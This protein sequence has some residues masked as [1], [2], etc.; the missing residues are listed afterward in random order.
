MRVWTLYPERA[1]RR[2]SLA[3]IPYS[4]WTSKASF[5]IPAAAAWTAICSMS[6]T[7]CVPR[8]TRIPVRAR[9]SRSMVTDRPR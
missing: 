1:S 8:Q 5:G 7:S 9:L 2:C 3:R 4:I 6:S